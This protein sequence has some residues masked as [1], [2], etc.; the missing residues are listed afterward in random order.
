MLLIIAIAGFTA[1]GVIA[2]RV[3]SAAIKR[4][5]DDIDNRD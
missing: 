2:L 3:I 4:M 1:A 5:F